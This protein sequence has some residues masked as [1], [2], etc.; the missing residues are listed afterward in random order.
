M[1][2]STPWRR[3]NMDAAFT[4]DMR[5]HVL[6]AVAAS[7]RL[8]DAMAEF[9][10]PQEVAYGRAR[11]DAEFRDALYS[12]LMDGRDP[13]LRHGSWTT[14]DRDGCRC[15][16]CQATQPSCTGARRWLQEQG[17]STPAGQADA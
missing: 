5:A 9:E 16:E 8:A 3:A 10:L 4:D 11:W 12:A 17:L 15:P 14:Y 6:R 7:T 13:R 1:D 2:R